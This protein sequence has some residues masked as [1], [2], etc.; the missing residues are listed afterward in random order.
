MGIGDA[1]ANVNQKEEATLRSR[2]N[3]LQ[4]HTDLYVLPSISSTHPNQ[5]VPRK[6]LNI[7]VN[8]KL[9]DPNFDK[10]HNVDLLLRADMFYDL[11]SFGN[12]KKYHSRN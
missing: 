2:L 8:I 11:Q 5:L 9:A 4:I 6:K 10:P 7:P 3:G 1:S 12:W